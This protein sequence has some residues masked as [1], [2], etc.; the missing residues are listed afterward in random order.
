MANTGKIP[1][2]PRSQQTPQTPDNRHRPGYD[3]DVKDGWLRGTG[4]DG[5]KPGFAPTNTS[6][7]P[8]TSGK[9]AR[10]T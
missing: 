4:G 1:T 7:S 6:R 10:R 5:R 2:P 8:A 3:A 9:G